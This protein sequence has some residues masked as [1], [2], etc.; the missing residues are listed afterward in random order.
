MATAIIEITGRHKGITETMRDYALSKVQRAIDDCVKIENVHII[1]DI[2]KYRHIAEIV[3]QGRDHL[4]F[5]VREISDDMCAS[6]DL[7]ADKVEQ[8][9]HKLKDKKVEK[10]LRAGKETL[11]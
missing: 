1:L 8:R 7:V 3:V 4:R 9:L 5:E 10:R 6:I 11:K 2:Q